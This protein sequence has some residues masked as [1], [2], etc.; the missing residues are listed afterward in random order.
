MNEIDRIQLG[1]IENI[2][3]ETKA[4]NIV[5]SAEKTN[6][7]NPPVPTNPAK[8]AEPKKYSLKD[9]RE[10]INKLAQET[11]DSIDKDLI[12][13]SVE[14]ARIREISEKLK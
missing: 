13:A 5:V 6:T 3:S 14:L 12:K 1:L 4:D 7:E 2:D 10:D 8:P 9:A 11:L